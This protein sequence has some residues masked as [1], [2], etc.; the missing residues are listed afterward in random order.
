MKKSILIFVFF[1]N[2]IINL[3]CNE[4]FT[5]YFIQSGQYFLL[6]LP[7]LI[8]NS[9]EYIFDNDTPL[10]IEIIDIRADGEKLFFIDDIRNISARTYFNINKRNFS[11]LHYITMYWI[12]WYSGEVIR[13]NDGRGVIFEET[14]PNTYILSTNTF[15]ITKNMEIIEITYRI[16]IPNISITINDLIDRN[17]N[18]LEFTDIY[19][20]LVRLEGIF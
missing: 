17:Y 14:S 18:V 6:D 10:A 11:G 5:G 2:V 8:D 15:E 20:I 12:Q 9:T 16:V 7:Y 3:W 4:Y 13:W 1:F 19:H